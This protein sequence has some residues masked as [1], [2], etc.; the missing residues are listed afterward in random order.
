MP[1]SRRLLLAAP[2]LLTVTHARAAGYPDRPVRLVIPYAPGGT[3]DLF[4]RLLAAQM[5]TRLGQTVVPENR[6]GAG[7]SLAGEVVA[8]AKPDG[9]TL[10]VS[11]NG[12][13]TVNPLIQANMP[14]DP[15]K[16]LQPVGLG[17]QVP[18]AV[19]V[20]ADHPA[21]TVQEFVAQ[22][23]AQKGAFT[24]GSSG[25]GSSNHLALELFNAATGADVTHVPYRGSGQMIPDLLAGNVTCLFD[26]ITTSLPMLR[27]G[28]VR[29][30]ALTSDHRSRLCQDV[31]TL[32]EAGFLG[33][34][35]VTYN[36]LSV[37]AGCPQDVLAKLVQANQESLKDPALRER[38]EGLGAEIASGALTTPEGFGAFIRADFERT[39]RA[40]NLAGLKPE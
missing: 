22:A 30:L 37:T 13:L 39:K 25:T 11:S 40:V 29:F 36:A 8:H 24:G 20:R 17:I 6:A 21:R 23:K 33:A 27:E 14:Y 35:M 26:Q 9:Y 15:F 34:E 2:A 5:S 12:P 38:L 31:P 16:D 4:G 3:T 19:V 18:L 32:A 1:V 7:G 28:K 10:L